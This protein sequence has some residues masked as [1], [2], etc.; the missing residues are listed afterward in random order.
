VDVRTGARPGEARPAIILCHGFKGFKDWGFFPRAAERLALAGFAAV[1]FNFSGSGVGEDGESF[2][3]LERWGGQTISGDLADLATVT[4]F[5]TE[6]GAPWVGLLGHSRGGATALVH[7]AR[8]VRVK[9]LVTWAAVSRYLRWPQDDID[10][11][12]RAG[13]IDVVNLRT[14]QVLPIGRDLLDDM[15]ANESG[16]LDV[17]GAAARLRVPWLIVH[18]TADETAPH[19]DA[20]RLHEASIKGG[21][22]S[23]L[24]MIEGAGHT[25]GVRHPWAGSSAEFDRVLAST[26]EFFSVALP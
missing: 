8:D 3:E 21:G 20:R 4:D 12:R 6:G 2:D 1:S 17:L 7:A 23:E 26:V 10:L 13:R 24:L 14:G 15:E 18:G 16:A 25:F 22:R 5:V 19:D 11:W 9:A